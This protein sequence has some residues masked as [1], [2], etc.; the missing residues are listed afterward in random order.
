MTDTIF[1]NTKQPDPYPLDD[2]E[3]AQRNISG[4]TKS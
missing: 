4:S 2:L 3:F 1:Y